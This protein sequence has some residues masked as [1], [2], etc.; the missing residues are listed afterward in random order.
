MGTRKRTPLNIN[1]LEF[2]IDNAQAQLAIDV[3]ASI[4]MFMSEA[5]A[6]AQPARTARLRLGETRTN[7]AAARSCALA[8]RLATCGSCNAL[9]AGCP[10]NFGVRTAGGSIDMY[11]AQ[12]DFGPLALSLIHISEPTRPY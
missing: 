1:A 5:L 11:N 6:K 2:T 4:H 3:C 9:R 7:V 12:T 8:A 10:N